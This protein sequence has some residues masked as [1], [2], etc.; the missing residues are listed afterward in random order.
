VRAILMAAADVPKH[1]VSDP[2][3]AACAPAP[4]R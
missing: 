2:V 3:R 4:T 1:P